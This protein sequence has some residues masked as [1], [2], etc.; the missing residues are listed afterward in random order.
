MCLSHGSLGH[1]YRALKTACR[2][3]DRSGDIWERVQRAK[4]RADSEHMPVFTSKLGS[5]TLGQAS[6]Q[7]LASF[8]STVP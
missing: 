3:D 6:D 2:Y 8:V 5:H 4:L 7:L 1:G